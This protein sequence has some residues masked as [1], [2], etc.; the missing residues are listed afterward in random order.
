[1]CLPDSSEE[2]PEELARGSPYTRSTSRAA[3][4]GT[5]QAADHVPELP[6]DVGQGQG[7]ARCPRP[8]A[9]AP[10][11]VD[12]HDR[13]VL[14]Q[15]I[16]RDELDPTHETAD[17]RIVEPPG[18]ILGEAEAPH[19]EQ[20]WRSR[21]GRLN[22]ASKIESGAVLPTIQADVDSRRTVTAPR[23][24]PRSWRPVGQRLARHRDPG[25]CRDSTDTA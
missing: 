15:R 2:C 19:R 25:N 14:R 8:P 24:P 4:G 7:P 12:L 23:H 10:T 20:S 16:V 17:P 3:P 22:F 6:L 9:A 1:M 11:C 21:T 5:Q 13:R 18:V